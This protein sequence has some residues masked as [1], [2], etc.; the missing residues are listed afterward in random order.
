MTKKRV[1]FYL[2][3]FLIGGIETS[4]LEYL[5]N[6]DE[7]KFDVTLVIGL[8]M[9]NCEAFHS[10]LKPHIK[11]KYVIDSKFFCMPFYKKKLGKLS[12]THKFLDNIFV[13]PIRSII[14]KKR[15]IN[16][17]NQFDLVIDYGLTLPKFINSITSRKIGFFHF[18]LKKHYANTPRKMK[19][20]KRALAYYDKIVI[21]TKL[22]LD[23]AWE[24]FP[25]FASKFYLLYNQINFNNLRQLACYHD[26]ENSLYNNY[27]VSVGRLEE[28]QKDFST[29]IKSFKILKDQYLRTESLIIIGDGEDY[30]KLQYLV[31]SLELTNQ[32][33]LVGYKANPF[34]WIKHSQLL[35]LSSKMEGMAMVLVEAM[36]LGKAV[37]SSDCPDGP[38]DVL[39]GGEC[40]ILVKVGAA[41]QLAAA[42]NDVLSNKEYK[43][44]LISN[45]NLHLDRFDIK[46]NIKQ[47]EKLI[48]NID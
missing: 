44:K 46:L 41:N 26:T 40:G 25:Q 13:S 48:T 32:V 1:A 39:L 24:L 8:K 20:I 11:I 33:K 21:L 14:F 10:R 17:L 22:M 30:N 3:M 37:I 12:Y 34:P 29:L 16:L 38:R 35:V 19:L 9:F 18:N 47:L 5:N 7:T 27:I 6:L 36:A 45:A 31:N 4:L 28:K 2:N 43:Q 42:I 23:D 15:L